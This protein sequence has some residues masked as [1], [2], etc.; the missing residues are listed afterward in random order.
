MK[1]FAGALF[2]LFI[3]GCQID[4]YTHAP[5]WTATDWYSAGIEDAI[6]GVAVKDNETLADAW[7]DPDVER[8]Q[9]LKGYAEG[10]R[11]TCQL[12]FVHARGLAG[13][14]VPASC[15]TVENASQLHDA[16]Q[17]GADEGVRSMRLN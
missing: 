7:N 12:N 14:T 11:K 13:K 5:T 8:T 4:P 3:S 9:Y 15:D 17:K 16:W 10:Q 2:V 6:S 1:R